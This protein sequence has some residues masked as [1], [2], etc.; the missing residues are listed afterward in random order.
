MIT[1][2]K[3]TDAMAGEQTLAFL[4]LRACIRAEQGDF[5]GVLADRKAALAITPDSPSQ[6]SLVE[7]LWTPLET[8]YPAY[9]AYLKSLPEK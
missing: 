7:S 9:A 3:A 2:V 6:T 5:P 8:R 4:R 1:A